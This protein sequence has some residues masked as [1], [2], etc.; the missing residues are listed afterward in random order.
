MHHPAEGRALDAKEER[1]LPPLRPRQAHLGNVS[2][3]RR[4]K[5]MKNNLSHHEMNSQQKSLEAATSACPAPTTPPS[6][7]K[8]MG[9]CQLRQGM[10]TIAPHG[11]MSI[12]ARYYYPLP[13]PTY[14][15]SSVR[16]C[17]LLQ[18]SIMGPIIQ[19]QLTPQTAGLDIR[20]Q[21]MRS[22]VR[23]AGLNGPDCDQLWRG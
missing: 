13:T 6:Q 9:P 2:G 16:L 7:K 10:K 23:R 21:G 22:C 19:P 12:R 20:A 18:T 3:A 1:P 11:I 15:P 17:A 8:Q 5:H 14:T 4:K